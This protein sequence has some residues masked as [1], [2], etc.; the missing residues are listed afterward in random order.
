[1]TIVEKIL[2]V[3][4][5]KAASLGFNEEELKSVAESLSANLTAGEDATDE[6]INAQVDAVMPVLKVSQSSANRT[7][8]KA[9]QQ[10]AKKT[11]PSKGAGD[12]D[13][14]KGDDMPDW[15]KSYIEKSEQRFNKLEGEKISASRKT[16]LTELVK[17]LGTFGNQ[18]LKAFDKMNFASDDEFE[19]Y[20]S[21]TKSDVESYSKEMSEKGLNVN[22]LGGNGGTPNKEASDD[23]AKFVAENM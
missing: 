3:L 2:K 21:E 8:N 5:T 13:E 18:I 14:P 7:I 11:D 15:F 1:M 19:T 12:D 23:E 22:P 16:K 6:D 9:K 20:L 10:P 17:D 4:K